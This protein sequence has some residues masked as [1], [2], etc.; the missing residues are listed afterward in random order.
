MPVYEV[1]QDTITI[2]QGDGFEYDLT[3]LDDTGTAVDLTG[4]DVWGGIKSNEKQ[5]TTL[6]DFTVAITNAAAGQL[7]ASLT[8]V[9]TQRGTVGPAGR[10]F[11]I[12][13]QLPAAQPQTAVE[14]CVEWNWVHE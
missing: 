13:Y 4:A 1:P 10:Y 11:F 12:K 7:T 14:G 6:V 9:Q 2:V 5:T 3:I 8:G